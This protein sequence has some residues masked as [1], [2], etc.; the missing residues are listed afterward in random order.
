MTTAVMPEWMVKEML[1]RKFGEEI[2]KAVDKS[3]MDE[4]RSREEQKTIYEKGRE[5]IEDII[6]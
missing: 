3:I 5:I 4:Y 1:A 6:F 2:A